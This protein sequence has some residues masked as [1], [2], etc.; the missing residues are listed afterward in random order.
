MRIRS[1]LGALSL[2]C[3]LCLLAAAASSVSAQ[4]GPPGARPAESQASDSLRPEIATTKPLYLPGETVLV[5]LTLVNPGDTGLELPMSHP[6]DDGAGLPS[7]LIF[8][9]EQAPTLYLG[10]EDEPMAPIRRPAAAEEAESSS[11]GAL[12]VAPRGILGAEVDLTAIHRALR[13][14][15]EYRLEWRPAG[16]KLGVAVTTFRVE[17][18][19]SVVIVTNQ[20]RLTFLLDYDNAPQNVANFLELARQGFYD[21]LTLHRLEPD[22]I[23]QGGCPQG[24]GRGMR[25]DGKTI[26]LEWSDR[27]FERGTLA[28]AHKPGDVNSASCQFFVALSRVDL[29]EPYTI[30]GHAASDETF[31][32]LEKLN[33]VKTENGK[34]TRAIRT[35][36]RLVPESRVVAQPRAG[37]QPP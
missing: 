10:F 19:Q 33:A 12:R 31:R 35:T 1:T 11:V 5:R 23:A 15:G 32:T 26:P 8:G 36:V 3:T 14:S 28:M 18:R 9:T 13:Y 21:D 25:P 24:T 7:A 29:E 20:G 22:F 17:Q 30:I 16:G 34:P 2:R 37:A 27:P 4:T 6:A